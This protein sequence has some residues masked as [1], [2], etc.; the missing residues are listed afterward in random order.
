MQFKAIL[1]HNQHK[2]NKTY[3]LLVMTNQ[4]WWKYLS[5]QHYLF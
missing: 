5:N 2:Q 1:F 3:P 4:K